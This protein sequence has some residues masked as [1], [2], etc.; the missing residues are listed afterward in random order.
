MSSIDIGRRAARNGSVSALVLALAAGLTACSPGSGLFDALGQSY[1]F[2]LS[3]G[4]LNLEPGESGS[5]TLEVACDR[6]GQISVTVTADDPAALTPLPPRVDVPCTTPGAADNNHFTGRS[7]LAIA[8][9]PAAPAGSQQL[10]FSASYGGQRPIER[11]L[12]LN[13]GPR[14]QLDVSTTPGGRVLSTPAG[15][16]CGSDCSERM[17]HG[18]LVQLTALPDAG[19]GLLAWTG[20]DSTN[21]STCTLTLSGDRQVGAQFAA[22][23]PLNLS[24]SGQGSVSSAPAGIQCGAD[25]SEAYLAGSSVQLLATPDSGHRFVAWGGACSGTA[26]STTVRMSSASACTASFAPVAGNPPP[27]VAGWS[28]D[29][30]VLAGGEGTAQAVAMVADR[31]VAGLRQAY[32][33]TAL[34]IA[35][36]SELIVERYEAGSPPLLAGSMSLLGTGSINS[37]ILPSTLAIAPAMALLAGTPA[38][39]W[40]DNGQR[41]RVKWWDGSTWQNLADNLATDP[42]H[43]VLG[44]QALVV[45]GELLVAWIEGGTMPNFSRVVLK[46]WNPGL[47]QWSGGFT[48]GTPD[49]ASALRLG[50]DASGAALL[51]VVADS[52]V[53]LSRETVPRVLREGAGGAWIDVCGAQI[54]IAPPGATVL[55][56]NGRHGFGVGS[57][58]ATGEVIAAFNNGEAAFAQVCRGGAWAGLDGSPEGRIGGATPPGET[59]SA[60]ALG[61]APDGSVGVAWARLVTRGI[62]LAESQVQVLVEGGAAT[63]WLPGGPMLGILQDGGPPVRS[64][65]LDFVAPGQPLLAMLAMYGAGQYPGRLFTY[66]P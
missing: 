31:S 34:T 40:A 1:S 46:R 42:G 25:C 23:L 6:D 9:Q 13:I 60:L 12:V 10:H 39:A 14:R 19:Q 55:T 8:A 66:R 11:V 37:G 54:S 57:S 26:A 28:D 17:P 3:T 22:L 5:V 24:V 32:T 43:T 63:A 50:T 44:V 33:A 64:L 41:L 65:G 58:A 21:G 27:G 53:T 52:A 2:S 59:F 49:G 61:R 48:A 56:P 4:S 16:D 51:M 47:G 15:I 45:R 38:V 36:R 18:G 7:A 20:C 62:D 30:V 29:G 35:G